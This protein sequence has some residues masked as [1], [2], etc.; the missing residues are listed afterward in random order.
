MR[1]HLNKLLLF[2]FVGYIAY[3]IYTLYVYCKPHLVAEGSGDSVTWDLRDVDSVDI[4][5][6]L[7]LK[8]SLPIATLQ[9]KSTSKSA[10]HI[11]LAKFEDLSPEMNS[12]R[13]DALVEALE[14][15]ESFFQNGTVFLHVLVV[16]HK[17]SDAKPLRYQVE[18]ISRFVVQPDRKIKTSYLLGSAP[19]G[20]TEEFKDVEGVVGVLPMCSL[21]KAVE[22]GFVWEP[23]ALDKQRLKDIGLTKYM[24][25]RKIKLPMYV[26]TLVSP[27]DEYTPLLQGGKPPSMELRLRNVGLGYWTMQQQIGMAFDEAERTMGLNEYD[28]DSFKQM[29]GGSSPF[30]ILLVYSV[31]ILHLI[32]E[33]LA[34]ASDISFWRAKTSFE[35]MSSSSV[36]LQACMNIIMFLYVQEQRQTKFVMYF[37][38]FRFCLQLWKLRKLT[39]LERCPSWPWFRWMNRAD[40]VEGFEELQEVHDSERRCMRGLLVVLLPVVGSFCAYRLIHYKFRS[41]YSWFVLSLAVCAQMGGFVVMTPQVFMN[42][43][44]KSVEHLPWR[45]LTYQAINTFIDDIFMLCIRMPEIQKYSVFRDDIIFVICCVQRWM[46]RKG[47][48]AV[49]DTAVTGPDAASHT[50]EAEKSKDD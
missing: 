11:L 38:A 42:W 39:V 49:S 2:G 26:N 29:V 33:Y 35:G 20:V 27:R 25:G 9:K 4:C 37:I 12:V 46:Y 1:C 50:T 28:V 40:A 7:A 31:A 34:F 17:K 13:P 3:E 30:K 5:I 36:A 47:T 18:R 43:R 14:L 23:S 24:E 48:L 19:A 45:A 10:A 41:W 22:V 15:P 44:L 6:Y 16:D 32:F 8:E 21:P